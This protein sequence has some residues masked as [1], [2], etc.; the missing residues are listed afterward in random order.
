MPGNTTGKP[1]PPI[2]IELI[3]FEKPGDPKTG[4][5]Q[6]GKGAENTKDIT[7]YIRTDA[8]KARAYEFLNSILASDM[9]GKFMR[10]QKS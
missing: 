4:D 8:Y 5:Q 3:H 7:D 10:R 1:H 6:S 9:R 2:N